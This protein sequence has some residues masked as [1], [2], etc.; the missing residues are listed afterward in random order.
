MAITISGTDGFS[1]DNDSLKFDEG[2]IIVDDDNNRV[3][4]GISSPTTSLDVS[5]TVNA[6]AY[7]GDGSGLTGIPTI[8]PFYKSDGSADNISITNSELPF[9]K[10]DGTASNIGVS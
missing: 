9:Y 4:I 7:T 2:T 3:G 10:A 1:S 5:G 8:F 6:T